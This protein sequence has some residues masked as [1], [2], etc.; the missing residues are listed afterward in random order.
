M[1][2][3]IGLNIGEKHTKQ[4]AKNSSQQNL[5]IQCFYKFHGKAL[6]NSQ[7]WMMA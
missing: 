6:L 4:D 2:T 5:S 7:P 1:Q 3:A